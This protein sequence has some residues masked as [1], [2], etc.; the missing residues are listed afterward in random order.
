MNTIVFNG[1]EAVKDNGGDYMII[2]ESG[3]Q[4][5]SV[6]SQHA[7]LPSALTQICTDKASRSGTLVRL[8][9]LE[10]AESEALA[11]SEVQEPE[12]EAPESTPE[13]APPLAEE[14]DEDLEDERPF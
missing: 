2:M 6:L 9:R 3:Y 12:L 14:M 4:G 13:V 5:F 10:V 1:S 11:G 8:I 7:D